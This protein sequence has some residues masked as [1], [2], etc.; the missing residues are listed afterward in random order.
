MI[1]KRIVC[2]YELKKV[3]T[4]LII[5]DDIK[6]Q[7][8]KQDDFDNVLDIFKQ[9]EDFLELGPEPYASKEMVLNDISYS[10]KCGSCYS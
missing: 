8:F 2:N 1:Y 3:D 5:K 6:I 9:S 4:M 7:E 10:Q